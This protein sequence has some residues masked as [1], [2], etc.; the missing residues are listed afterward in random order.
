[1]P[2]SGWIC[3]SLI[4]TNVN[5]GGIQLGVL[6]TTVSSFEKRLHPLL[7]FACFALF[8]LICFDFEL[9]MQQRVT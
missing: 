4:V 3:I 2:H 7:P 8:T 5:F 1:M 6:L 9:A